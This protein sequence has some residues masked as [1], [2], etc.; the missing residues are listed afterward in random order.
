MSFKKTPYIPNEMNT[1]QPPATKSKAYFALFLTSFLWGTTWI[2]GK[3][4]IQGIHP[5]FY[6][7]IRQ[8]IA[9]CCFLAF[10]IITK[11]A[12]LPTRKEWAYLLGMAI[13]LFVISNA[14]TIWS[15]QYLNS[16]LGA[17]L[18]AVF[19]LW[20]A[21]IEWIIGD[22]NRPNLL[23]VMGLLIGLA[24]VMLIFYEHLAD[25]SS[26]GF[27]TGVLMQ[28]TATIAWAIG[29]VIMGRNTV[30]LGRYYS[31]GWQ[32]LM[33]GTILLVVCGF[34]GLAMPL[35]QIP[36]HVWLSIGYMV[37]F[38]SIVTFSALLYTLQHLP[39]TLASV[40]AYINPIVAVVLGHF[41]LDENWS[42]TLVLGALITL[43]GVYLV[44]SGFRRSEKKK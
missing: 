2:V 1:H 38:G 42:L 36:T 39:S 11:K 14:M 17:I 23:S 32:M 10:F 24:G 29:T 19:P 27:V 31:V 13:L 43:V 8:T 25:F 28:L 26:N 33:S 37:L 7:A 35:R 12:V 34:G 9:G 3:L 16:G 5:L 41:I 21:I 18:G 20:V 6:S 4:G 40:Y 30:Q 15:V 44:N 22:K